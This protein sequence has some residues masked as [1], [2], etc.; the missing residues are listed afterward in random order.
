MRE[1]KG[2]KDCH[3]T[4][5][6]RDASQ[7]VGVTTRCF[8]GICH[9]HPK[10]RMASLYKQIATSSTTANCSNNSHL[11]HHHCR[12]R[13]HQQQQELRR[14]KS[15]TVSPSTSPPPAPVPTPNGRQPTAIRSTRPAPL[16]SAPLKQQR[17]QQQTIIGRTA[18]AT[19]AVAA[20]VVTKTST[21][22]DSNTNI[23]IMQVPPQQQCRAEQ[24][25]YQ[26]LPQQR[27]QCPQEWQQQARKR[28]QQ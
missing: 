9:V 14:R 27:L 7:G 11:R 25:A 5:G 10:A 20:A 17:R 15:R 18:A 8:R 4:E 2:D 22:I 19:A 16:Q 24:Q 28:Q 23:K 6:P 13:Q 3:S 21:R 26:K 12:L 1:E